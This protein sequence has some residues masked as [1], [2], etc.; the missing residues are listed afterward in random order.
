[1]RRHWQLLFLGFLGLMTS[2]SLDQLKSAIEA[3]KQQNAAANTTTL[4]L[5]VTHSY[6]QGV[7]VQSAAADGIKRI[8]E[9]F[10]WRQL[11][12]R[13]EQYTFT[14]LDRAVNEAAKAGLKVSLLIEFTSVDCVFPQMTDRECFLDTLPHDV[15]FS[16][17][18]S[19][20]DDD[21]IVNRLMALIHLIMERYDAKVLTH[22]YLG[23]EVDSYLRVVQTA[24]EGKINLDPGYVNLIKRIKESLSW[25]P[26]NRPTFG[27][28]IT[29]CGATWC[30]SFTKKVAKVVE[31][32]GLNIYPTDPDWGANAPEEELT[33]IVRRW[34]DGAREATGNRPFAINETGASC[35]A[36]YGSPESQARYAQLL[37]DYLRQYKDTI[38][39]AV[40]FSMYDNPPLTQTF[41]FFGKIGLKTLDDS[42]RP[43]YEIWAKQ[44]G[45]I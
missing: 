20:F 4:D 2:C 9:Y 43:A 22:V 29:Y 30:H 32:I 24:S 42:K 23:N 11:E 1:M 10:T 45:S 17:E 16:R 8:N 25:L 39:Y 18:T 44:G 3:A 38:P 7:D 27:T 36:P 19:R 28:N 33:S 5:G 40:W 34:L 21:P 26:K 41:P 31:I 6:T 13:A 14:E 12:P 37:I 35:V 15:T